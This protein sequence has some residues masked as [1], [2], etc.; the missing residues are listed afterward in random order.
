MAG[1]NETNP[2]PN[3]NPNP[4]GPPARPEWLPE[5]FWDASKNEAR[6]Q[7]LAQSFSHLEKKFGEGKAAYDAERLKGRP[8]K[9]DGYSLKFDPAKLPQGLVILDKEPGA[10]FK[11]EPG[12]SYFVPKDDDMMKFWRQ[13]CFDN[14]IGQDGFQAGI[15]Q[16]A[17]MMGAATPTPEQLAASRKETYAKLGEHGEQRV[18]HVWGRLQHLLGEKASTLDELV[19]TPEAVEAL[20]ALLERAGEPKFSPGGGVPN[21]Q[22]ASAAAAEIKKLE[23]DAEFQ[24]KILDRNHPEH[25]EAFKKLQKLHE[26]AA[27][28]A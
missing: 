17:K 27:R 9:V 18:Q 25:A 8:E 14:G 5:K 4:G 7:D 1:E 26:Q 15:L 13:H 3:P 2:N 11:P 24:K 19:D 16:F 12:K 6:T 22:G 21:A 28:A 23:G 20:E 10:D